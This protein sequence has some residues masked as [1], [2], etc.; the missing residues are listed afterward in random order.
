MT[1][2]KTE[3]HEQLPPLDPRTAE[4]GCCPRFDPS[5]WDGKIFKLDG[6]LFAKAQ[7]RSFMFMPINMDKV[8]TRT[9]AAINAAEAA[10]ND[11]Y[12]ILSKDISKW[13]ADHFFLVKK[14]I[15]SL[16]TCT[17][18]GNYLARVF[19]GPF[20]DMPKWISTFTK[21]VESTDQKVMD[22]YAFYTTC[23]RCAKQYGKNYVVLLGKLA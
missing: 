8:F 11:R 2:N 1:T 18:D 5:L 16:E 12:L 22:I 4:T 7:T 15:P 17:L 9:L 21:A 6:L 23:P 13:K 19:Q 14:D 20:Q 10:F 3:L